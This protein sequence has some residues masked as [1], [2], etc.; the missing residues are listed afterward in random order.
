MRVEIQHQRELEIER[1]V[2]NLLDQAIGKGRSVVKATVALDWDVVEQK[3]E[4]F[5]P[6]T[7]QPQTRSQK[8][9][10]ESFAGQGADAQAAAGGVPGTQANIPTYQAGA[11]GGAGGGTSSYQR[12]G[13][14][15]VRHDDV[16]EPCQDD[17]GRDRPGTS[18]RPHPDGC[19]GRWVGGCTDRHGAPLPDAVSEHPPSRC[20]S[21]R[22]RRRCRPPSGR[23]GWSCRAP[24]A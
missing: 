13:D 14:G 9:T 10:R 8:D 6:G 5:S 7:L 23:Q 11:A 17:R 18:E 4:T 19:E 1:K 21:C 2:Q 15:A 24:D 22:W 16:G 3:V 20:R 12:G